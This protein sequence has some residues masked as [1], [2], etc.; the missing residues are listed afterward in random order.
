M[1]EDPQEVPTDLPREIDLG[2]DEL[3]RLSGAS[4][5]APVVR[6]PWWKRHSLV[7]AL[8]VSWS[9]HVLFFAVWMGL[10]WPK[11]KAQPIRY[12]PV[13]LV[14]LPDSKK[15]LDKSRQV[16]ALSNADHQA[17]APAGPDRSERSP[18]AS[19]LPP[20]PPPAEGEKP[21]AASPPPPP[22][23]PPQPESPRPAAPA[24]VAEPE[25]PK[26][27]PPPPESPRP[28]SPQSKKS[29]ASQSRAQPPQPAKSKAA[30]G[31]APP[32]TE[33]TENAKSQPPIP[34]VQVPFPQ[35]QEPAL[36]NLNLTPSL[37]EV[38]R[39]DM[40]RQRRARQEVFKRYEETVSLN[41]QKSRYVS[42]FTRLKGR[43]QQAWVYPAQAKRD[44]L[45]GTLAMSFTINQDGSIS[46]IRVLKS[47][48]VE[49]LDLAAV[50][51]V[52]KATP[53]MPL[54]EDWGLEKLHVKTIFEYVQGGLRWSSQ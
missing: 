2:L 46:D 5:T 30:E 29:P 32:R 33:K 22:P 15:K 18:L 53:F 34:V 31:A 36:P 13:E 28:A 43:I 40:E 42:Y 19:S 20:A 9:L 10:G 50:Q 8:V 21:A 3:S 25:S 1:E 35:A 6:L 54:P 26:P 45:S 44:K 24:T 37:G 49:V 41:T 4:E 51:A 38:A 27:A 14:Q 16:D 23:P 12:M 17:D 48:G 47:S 52:E 7:L 39:W 11:A